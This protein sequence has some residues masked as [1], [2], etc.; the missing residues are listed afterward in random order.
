MHAQTY[1]I[2]LDNQLSQIS[3]I[4]HASECLISDEKSLQWLFFSPSKKRFHVHYA[5]DV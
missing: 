2:L 4:L 1:E 5:C 3:L